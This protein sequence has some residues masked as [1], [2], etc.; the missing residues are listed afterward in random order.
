V[1]GWP[2]S[3]AV[4][5]A[6]KVGSNRCSNSLEKCNLTAFDETGTKSK[7][8]SKVAAPEAILDL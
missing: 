4:T 8:M 2:K 6:G 1:N 5:V 7:L 3:T